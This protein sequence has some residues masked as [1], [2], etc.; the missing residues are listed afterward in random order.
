V[1]R[2]YP[3]EFR[4]DVVRVARNRDDGVTIE[5]SPPISVCHGVGGP[6]RHAPGCRR[7]RSRSHRRH[8]WQRPSWPNTACESA[9]SSP[10]AKSCSASTDTSSTSCTTTCSPT[11]CPARSASN[12]RSP[13]TASSWWPANAY[14][15][16]APT[17]AKIVTIHVVDTHFRVTRDGAQLSVQPRTTELPI[18]R[19]KAKI[20][21]PRPNSTS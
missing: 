14:V 19:W 12:A 10:D 13:E 9:A 18:R 2:P 6:R 3:R 16:D 15:S 8:Q 17:P 4:D 11:H 5:Q 7:D 20:H 1:A 21:A